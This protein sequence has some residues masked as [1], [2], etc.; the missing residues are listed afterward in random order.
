MLSDDLREACM[1][2]LRMSRETCRN[3]ALG[4]S[5]ERSAQQFVANLS[6]L[7][8]SVRTPRAA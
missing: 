3:F 7:N 2:A 4:H 6:N 1:G 8:G 5:W